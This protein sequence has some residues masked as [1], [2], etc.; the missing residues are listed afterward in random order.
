AGPEQQR[1][2]D[3]VMRP[4]ID[5]MRMN[6]MVF[7]GFLYAGLMMTAEGP[8]VLEFNC[9]LGDPETQAMMHRLGSDIAP[10]LLAVAKGKLNE[11]A[12]AWKPEPSVCVVIAAAGYPGKVR[13]G[14]PI[15]GIER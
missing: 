12:L 6:G 3:V 11:N 5:Y 7:T 1:I 8:K 9:R 13:S 14:D 4:A 10:S 2:L 15:L